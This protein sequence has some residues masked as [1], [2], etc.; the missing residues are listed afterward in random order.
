MKKSITIIVISLIVGV[1]HAEPN[2]DPTIEYLVNDKVTMLDWGMFRLEQIIESH[3][4]MNQEFPSAQVD[5]NYSSMTGDIFIGIT[6]F[7]KYPDNV[8]KTEDCIYTIESIEAWHRERPLE[9][10]FMHKGIQLEDMPKNFRQRIHELTYVT[11]KAVN[12][13]DGRMFG[14]L[15]GE[16][17]SSLVKGDN[18]HCR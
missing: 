4:E 6:I 1:C 7:G 5:V 2:M 8:L 16:C 13:R 15:G 17:Y 11:V 10:N 18:I 3:L 12:F 14:T 9:L